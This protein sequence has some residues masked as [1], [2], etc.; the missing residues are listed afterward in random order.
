VFSAAQSLL[1]LKPRRQRKSLARGLRVEVAANARHLLEVRCD[2]GISSDVPFSLR[3]G[4][5]VYGSVEHD[6][7]D[8][9]TK[10]VSQVVLLY[11]DFEFRP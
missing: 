10:L 5:L 6:L 2:L 9:P 7:G 4:T 8:L 11:R 1:W 3:V